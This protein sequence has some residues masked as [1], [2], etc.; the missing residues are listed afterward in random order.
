MRGWRGGFELQNYGDGLADD[1]TLEA[2]TGNIIL[3]SSITSSTDTI[4][5]RGDV[6]LVNN[7]SATIVDQRQ[8]ERLNLN[9]GR[10][11]WEGFYPAEIASATAGQVW[12]EATADHTTVGSFGEQVGKKLLTLAQFLGLK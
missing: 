11:S 7:S 2:A 5:I 10:G 3:D 1:C 6:S 9:H 8:D 4:V 12:E